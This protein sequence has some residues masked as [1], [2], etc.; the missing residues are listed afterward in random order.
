M[1]AKFESKKMS[2]ASIDFKS[3]KSYL[4][5]LKHIIIL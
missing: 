4:S 5:Y 2:R 3:N 1:H